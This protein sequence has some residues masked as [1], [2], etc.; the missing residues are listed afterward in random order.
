MAFLHTDVNMFEHPLHTTSAGISSTK[1]LNMSPKE[2]HESDAFCSTMTRAMF[3]EFCDLPMARKKSYEILQRLAKQA[4]ADLTTDQMI[5]SIKIPGNCNDEWIHF[6]V[7]SSVRSAAISSIF[8]SSFEDME[9]GNNEEM[10]RVL[11]LLTE[12]LRTKKI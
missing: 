2:L 10:T 4:I 6:D 1:N 3:T 11:S 5:K 7:N 12:L 8:T 9:R